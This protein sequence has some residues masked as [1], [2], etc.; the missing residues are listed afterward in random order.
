[1]S[2]VDFSGTAITVGIFSHKMK[3]DDAIIGVIS[4]VSKI[5]AGF[6]YAFATTTWMIYLGENNLF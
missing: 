1:M 5:L 4:C 2:F 3:M 6:I